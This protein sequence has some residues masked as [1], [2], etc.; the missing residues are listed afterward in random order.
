MRLVFLFP[1]CRYSW[2]IVEC[3]RCKSHIGW[4]FQAVG[5]LKPA[6]FWGLARRSVIFK[7]DF[8]SDSDIQ[9]NLDTQHRTPPNSANSETFSTVALFEA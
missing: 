8:G 9:E 4:K 6:R 1:S 7:Y 3:K 2:T 5:R